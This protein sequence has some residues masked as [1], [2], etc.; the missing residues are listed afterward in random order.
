MQLFLLLSAQAKQTKQVIFQHNLRT[1]TVLD[2]NG[3]HWRI[4][5]PPL[6]WF[7]RPAPEN[8]VIEI[9]SDDE[10]SEKC[11]GLN[12]T[13]KGTTKKIVGCAVKDPQEPEHCRIYIDE[14][15][16]AQSKKTVIHHERAHCHGWPKYHPTGEALPLPRPNPIGAVRKQ[17]DKAK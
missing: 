11:K 17:E 2:K 10:V 3:N 6:H 15:L 12:E 1:F 7:Q 13:L 5:D 9:V 14:N 16:I 4:I 8:I